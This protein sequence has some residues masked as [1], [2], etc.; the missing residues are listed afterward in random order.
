MKPYAFLPIRKT[1][2]A[3]TRLSTALSQKKR[4]VLCQKMLRHVYQSCL[5]AGVKPVVV[6]ADPAILRKYGGL[7]D[8]NQGLNEAVTKALET[9]QPER[10]FIILPD[11]PFLRHENLLQIMK[12]NSEYVV[13]PDRRLTGTNIVYVNGFKKFQTMFGKHSF[14]K[15]LLQNNKAKIFCELGTALD[16]DYPS[17]LSLFRRLSTRPTGKKQQSYYKNQGHE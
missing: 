4:I 9:L 2:T 5:E 1:D 7:Q 3:K 14:R 13:C 15:H 8:D 17:D 12:L 10:F 6:T 16:I 11:L